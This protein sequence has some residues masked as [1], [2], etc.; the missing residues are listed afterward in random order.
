MLSPARSRARMSVDD[1]SGVRRVDAENRGSCAGFDVGTSTAGCMRA[2]SAGSRCRAAPPTVMPGT[3]NDDEVRQVEDLGIAMP[4]FDFRKRVGAGDEENL[5]RPAVRAARS[6]S[7]VSA[8]YDGPSLRAARRRR[9]SRVDAVDTASAAIANR[10]NGDASGLRRPVRRDVRR[11]HAAPGRARGRRAP[12]ARSRYDR[13]ES[14]RA[15]RRGC[16][17]ARPAVIIR[18]SSRCGDAADARVACQRATSRQTASSS[19]V[20]PSPVAADTA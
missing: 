14:D 8:V 6:R 1:T 15:C 11:H 9:P 12:P 4:R 10:W 2:A 20:R 19:A 16:R 18:R 13:R 5:R 3:R 7:S 17:R